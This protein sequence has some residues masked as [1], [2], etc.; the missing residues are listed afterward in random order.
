[1]TV[2]DSEK[3]QKCIN[4]CF[5]NQSKYLS[6]ICD[7]WKFESTYFEAIK[8]IIIDV[9]SIFSINDS[10]F[11]TK[12]FKNTVKQLKRGKLPFNKVITVSITRIIFM[13]FSCYFDDNNN[14]S[15][16]HGG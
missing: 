11:E 6:F 9:S 2:L 16:A 13:M 5:L 4:I 7:E 10:E 3:H 12:R 8:G 15:Q 14:L 1:M